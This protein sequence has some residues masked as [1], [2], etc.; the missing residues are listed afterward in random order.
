MPQ[1]VR[2]KYVDESD[3]LYLE[4]ELQRIILMGDL[5]VQTSVTGIIPM[6]YNKWSFDAA[7][8]TLFGSYFLYIILNVYSL[9]FTPLMVVHVMY[10]KES[11]WPNGQVL[12]Q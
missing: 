7:Y 4:D 10:S 2:T 9:H 3:K 11:T 8:C 6:I 1:P 5:D 12:G